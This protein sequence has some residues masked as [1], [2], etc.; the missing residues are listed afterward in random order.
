MSG[1]LRRVAVANVAAGCGG[2]CRRIVRQCDEFAMLQCFPLP[3]P[4]GIMRV[5]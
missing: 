4:S 3:D 5:S 2:E 1:S